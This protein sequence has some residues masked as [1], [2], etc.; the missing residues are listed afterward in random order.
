MVPE[1]QHTMTKGAFPKMKLGTLGRFAAVFL[2]AFVGVYFSLGLSARPKPA[3]AG[4][5][6]IK[7]ISLPA[8]P[9]GDEYYDY[10]S[11]DPE[12]RRVYVS[13]GTEVVVLNA[14]DYS[15]VGKIEG[16]SRSHGVAIAKDLGTGFI[17][18][19]DGR[20]G[21]TVQQVVFFDLKTLKVTGK[22]STNQ[23]D[24]DA[25]IY[26]PVTKHVY[27]FNG[28]SHNSTV[29]DPAKQAVITNI[30]LI[31][32]VEFPAVDG[33][34]MI[35]D[36]NPEKNDIVAIDARTN[37][38]KARWP[39]S[40][41]GQPT[42]MAIDQKTRRLFS[43]GRGPQFVTMMDAD[44]GKVLASYPISGG[45]DA[46]AF[47]PGT[48]LLFVSTR[49]GMLHIYHEDS[50][51]KLSEVESVKT[52]YGAKTSQVDPKTHKVFLSTSDFNPPAAPTE[53]Q[54]HPLPA[55]KPGNF[56]VLVYGR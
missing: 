23:P 24:T 43:G 49:E 28:D 55:A 56:R 10:I 8:A 47:D 33:K 2:F 53:K 5:H 4:Y 42:S 32:K 1:S 25:I 30:D 7:T 44:N 51:G 15:I 22:V 3:A 52:E 41:E 45:V 40:P 48:G 34:G 50:P 37:T 16:L 18:D 17:S 6:L 21:A 29:I 26:E 9:G 39:T 36:D 38:I 46:N 31:G 19:G 35:Y 20:P 11:I 14:D 27:T 54:P 12:A 13:H